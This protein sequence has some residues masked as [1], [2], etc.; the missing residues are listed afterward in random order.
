MKSNYTGHGWEGKNYNRNLRIADIAKIVRKFLK[1]NLKKYKF[2]VTT[3]MFS[4][5]SALNVSLM[6]APMKVFVDFLDENKV[7]KDFE[8]QKLR[9][10]SYHEKNYMQINDF[11]IKEDNFLTAK[12]KVIF[13][14]VFK[15]VN[16]F[17]YDDSD[18]QIDY[19]D[20]NF[21][22]HLNVGKYDKPYIQIS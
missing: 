4:G 8:Y 13:M 2:S 17:N 20:T 6:S 11:Y 7:Y 15:F 22:V 9:L 1:D 5:G 18:S 10:K 3:E 14:K 12:C 21:Y 19:F 16:S